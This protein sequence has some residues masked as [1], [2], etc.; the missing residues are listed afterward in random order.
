MALAN[1]LP[2][3]RAE[4]SRQ[5]AQVRRARSALAE[6]VRAGLLAEQTEAVAKTASTTQAA[7]QSDFGPQQFIQDAGYVEADNLVDQYRGG[8]IG[9]ID[10][11]A[12]AANSAEDQATGRMK[13]ALQRNEDNNLAA[14]EMAEDAVD[15]QIAKAAQGDPSVASVTDLD[16]AINQVASTLPDGLPVDQA[17]VVAVPWGLS[18]AAS[19]EQ[20]SVSF[21]PRGFGFEPTQV[22][23]AL[24]EKALRSRVA[25][26]PSDVSYIGRYPAVEETPPQIGRFPGSLGTSAG[27]AVVFTPATP[28][29]TN[30]TRGGVEFTVQEGRI[31][32]RPARVT[33]LPRGT[34][35]E[36]IDFPVPAAKVFS[37]EEAAAK[38]AEFET[39]RE[40]QIQSAMAKGLSEARAKRNVLITESQQQALESALPSYSAEDVLSRSNVRSYGDVSEAERFSEVKM[41]SKTGRLTALEEGGFLEAQQDP[42]TIRTEPQQAR[43]GSMI[44]PASKTSYRGVTGRP[45]EGLYGLIPPIPS[46][47]VAPGMA[48]T[49]GPGSIKASKL[50]Q[51]LN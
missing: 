20:T 43:I 26:T 28:G 24:Q 9:R 16:S 47:Q 6:E 8:A 10:Q 3:N 1:V 29:L 46:Q 2:E 11:F 30:V 17:E 14:I 33:V 51:E 18:R 36:G 37:P 49:F 44:S 34:T 21:S 19:K 13:M 45:G 39:S 48:E 25:A 4:Q 7:A 41:A 22:G 12:N 5:Q 31:G 15:A 40:A 32:D 35:T 23:Q 42:G 50:T 27:E 38:L